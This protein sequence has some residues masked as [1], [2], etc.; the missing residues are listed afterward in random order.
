MTV[1][2]ALILTKSYKPVR[3]INLPHNVDDVKLDKNKTY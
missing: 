1:Q 3:E 2:K